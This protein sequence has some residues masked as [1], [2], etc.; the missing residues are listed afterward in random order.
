[1]RLFQCLFRVQVCVFGFLDLGKKV[2]GSIPSWGGVKE[3]GLPMGTYEEMGKGE[4]RMDGISM[5]DRLSRGFHDVVLRYKLLL[6]RL[7]PVSAGMGLGIGYPAAF[8]ISARC[9]L[10]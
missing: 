5:D 8:F 10:S 7:L 9:K 3:K 2:V 1:V 6:Q 4:I